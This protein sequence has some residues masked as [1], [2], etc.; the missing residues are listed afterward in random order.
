MSFDEDQPVF[1]PT[2]SADAYLLDVKFVHGFRG[3]KASVFSPSSHA[4]GPLKCHTNFDSFL[5]HIVGL[6]IR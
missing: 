5:L 6:E 3:C 1:A 4:Q 2:C